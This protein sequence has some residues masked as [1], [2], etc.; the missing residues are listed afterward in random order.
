MWLLMLGIGILWGM[1]MIPIVLLLLALTA[2]VAGLPGYL[3]YQRTR[4]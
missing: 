3:I 4:A 1:L 2:A